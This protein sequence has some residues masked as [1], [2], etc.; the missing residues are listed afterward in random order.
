MPDKEDDEADNSNCETDLPYG[1]GQ[2]AQRILSRDTAS[3][4][5]C[6]DSSQISYVGTASQPAS[7][8]GTWIH[9]RQHCRVA[10]RSDPLLLPSPPL[11][12]M[13]LGPWHARP[14][15][16]LAPAIST[17]CSL[18]AISKTR[19]DEAWK[20][21]L[22]RGGLRICGNQRHRA[23]PLAVHPNSHH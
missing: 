2:D 4:Q 12:H 17:S 21:H 6:E 16:G 7:Q 15:G 11:R 23:P 9:I 13:H 22:Q 20:E 18:T 8:A 14:E 10:K 5:A 3:E 1:C 19:E